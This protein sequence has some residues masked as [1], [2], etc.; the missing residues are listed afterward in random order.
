MTDCTL[1]SLACTIC[2]KSYKILLF[3]VRPPSQPL[4]GGV[5]FVQGN[6]RD[7]GMSGREQLNQKLT[8][9]VNIQE[10]ENVIKACVALGVPRV[11][12]TC[13]VVFGGQVIHSSNE[14]L[15]YLPLHLHPDHYIRT[16]LIAERQVLEANGVLLA[17]GRGVLQTCALRFAGIYGSGEQ[18][19]LPRIV[20]YIKCGLFRF[21]YGNPGSLVEFVHI[22]I[23][24][25]AH[26]LAAAALTKE[27]GCHAAGQA[28]F[29]Y[30]GWPVNNLEFFRPL[31]EGLRYSFPRLHLPL[32]LVYHFAFLTEMVHRVVGRT[33]DFQPLLTRTRP[34]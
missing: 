31:V 19:H 27:R 30:D 3:D 34:P 25:S 16:K 23:L 33:Y 26:A 2:K 28:Y 7:Y 20:G 9:E 10:T 17:G 18:R 21:V 14:T 22:N 15:P 11:V 29:I 4:P 6:V 32:S 24:T 1:R 12:F 5:E 13:N 8:E